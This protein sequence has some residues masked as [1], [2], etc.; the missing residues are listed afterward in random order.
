MRKCIVSGA[1][2]T[3]A[4]AAGGL[5]VLADDWTAVRLRGGVFALENGAWVQ[6]FKGSVVPDDRVIKSAPD[7]RITLVRGQ[8]TI[9]FGPDTTAQIADDG[10]FT[11]VYN[12]AGTVGIDAEAR[13]VQHFAVQTDYLAAIVKGTAF[14]VA[15]SGGGSTVVV[16]R[17]TVAVEDARSEGSAVFVEAG[18]QVS[19]GETPITSESVVALAVNSF[20]PPPRASTLPSA[21]Q[22]AFEGASNGN[23]NADGNGNGN[24]DDDDDGDDDDDDDGNDDDDDDDD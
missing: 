8:E 4:M 22:P 10:G 17:G 20:A 15:T 18:Q 9:E 23:G 7:G 2:V 6:L 11:T 1:V 3:I 12:H 5:P 19:T 14:T 24:D 21:A 16:T 13:N